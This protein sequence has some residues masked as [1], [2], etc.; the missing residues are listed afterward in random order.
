ME[1][2]IAKHAKNISGMIAKT[3]GIEIYSLCFCGSG[4]KFKFCCYNKSG[5]EIVFSKKPIEDS[6]KYRDSQ[7]GHMSSLPLGIFNTF[8]EY[9]ISRLKCL[10]PD[11]DNVPVS[12]HLIPENI[13]RTIFVKNSGC[14]MVQLLASF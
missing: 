10:Y 3:L 7:G 4:K 13:L 11:C 12:C 2:Q 6:V 5:T 8:K 1:E 9:S 14:T